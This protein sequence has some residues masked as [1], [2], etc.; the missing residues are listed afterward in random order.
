LYQILKVC[1]PDSSDSADSGPE[2]PGRSGRPSEA[3]SWTTAVM[4]DGRA[5]GRSTAASSW[6]LLRAGSRG[7]AWAPAIAE[8]AITSPTAATAA[9]G[10][11]H[12]A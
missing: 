7:A 6:A 3:V 2:D 12:R 5:A 8:P 9:A 4:A 1:V 10:T 11:A